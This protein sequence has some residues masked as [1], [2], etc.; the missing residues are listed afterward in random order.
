MSVFVQ[1]STQRQSHSSCFMKALAGIRQISKVGFLFAILLENFTRAQK[2][3]TK[4]SLVPLVTN[5]MSEITYIPIQN[6][7]MKTM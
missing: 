6:V 2:Y 7:Q 5:S 4:V 1:L 3:L